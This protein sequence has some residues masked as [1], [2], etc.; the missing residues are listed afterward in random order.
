[1]LSATTAVVAVAAV[2]KIVG[3]MAKAMALATIEEDTGGSVVQRKHPLCII[4][5]VVSEPG[6]VAVIRVALVDS[7]SGLRSSQESSSPS[8]EASAHY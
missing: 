3:M 1:M 8:Q 2:N 5:A 6:D 4:M 7:S